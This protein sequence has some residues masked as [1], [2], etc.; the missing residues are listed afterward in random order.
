M[1]LSPDHYGLLLL[2]TI[3]PA[4]VLLRLSWDKL[5]KP[6]G[7]WLAL[8]LVG[9]A[10]W[11][12]CW[13]VVLLVD[14]PATSV[15]GLNGVLLFVDL[16]TIGW[17][18]LALE[19]TRQKRYGLLTVAPLFFVPAMTQV[20]ALTNHSH[21]LLWGPEV[22]LDATVQFFI[23]QG[24]WFYV[25]TGF[26]YLLLL[27]SG[28]L[29]VTKFVELDGIY[30][31]QSAVL[32]AGWSIPVVSSIAFNYGLF[33]S[34]YVNPTPIGFLAG[35][36]IWGWGQYRFKLLEIA[37]VARRR[38]LD[39]MD[40]AVFAVNEN[41]VI[42]YLNDAAQSMFDLGRDATGKQLE[43]VLAAYPEILDRITEEQSNEEVTLT[44]DG[45]RRYLSLTITGLNS[46]SRSGGSVI[47][48]KDVTELKRHERDLDLLKQVFARVFRHDL[49]ND[50]NVVR[51]HAELL[52]ANVDDSQARHAD[53]ILRK[54]DGIIETSR[55]ARAIEKL[56]DVDRD[57][58][59]ID[60]VHVVT[61]VVD[62]VETNFDDVT[63][64]TDLPRDGF[65]CAD[66]EL[67]LAVRCLV[68]NALVHNDAPDPWVGITVTERPDELVL[69]IEDNGP[70]IEAN[71]RHVF[72]HRHVD[73]LSHSSGLGLW[74]V[75]WVVRNSK[76]EAQ[77]DVTERGTRFELRLERVSPE[78]TAKSAVDD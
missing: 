67:E 30:R 36:A 44:R 27:I 10:G 17:F 48:C 12:V 39:E 38:A 32:L 74:T 45:C 68:E 16:S 76:G 59:E 9:L 78:D 65:V 69:I 35:A 37:P 22:A 47:V 29:M 77:F 56:V 8:T 40:E 34:T 25:H 14:D 73:Q 28:L 6:G 60:L 41:G 62:W 71:E 13:A 19:F 26:N 52:S 42:A 43:E 63:V 46:R 64:E 21:M 66:G 33:G 72:E 3:L 18:L 50:L 20:L 75:N 61:E 57:R 58:Y 54:C 49:S 70:G 24:P 53:T 23:D 11:S 31:K 7:R 5:D 2:L 51:A 55:K 15:A 4:G 1:V